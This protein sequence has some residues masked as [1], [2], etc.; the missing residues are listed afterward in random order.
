MSP[1]VSPALPVNSVGTAT[2]RNVLPLFDKDNAFNVATPVA[3]LTVPVTVVPVNTL[4]LTTPPTARLPPAFTVMLVPP[5][6]I[7][8][9]PTYKLFHCLLA[10]PKFCPRLVSGNKSPVALTLTVY[11]PL[12]NV[13]IFGGV[14]VNTPVELLYA[15]PPLSLGVASVPVDMLDKVIYPLRSLDCKGV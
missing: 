4:T 9:V 5:T 3:V 7:V 13:V 15:M 2:G 8:L 14:Y 10:L 11:V 6:Y 12:Y 1:T